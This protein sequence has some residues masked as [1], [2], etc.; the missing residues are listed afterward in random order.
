MVVDTE[1]IQ[2]AGQ[3]VTHAIACTLPGVECEDGKWVLSLY[4]ARTPQAQQHETSRD[5]AN[6]NEELNVEQ[7]IDLDEILRLRDC[8]W[9]DS[10]MNDPNFEILD[11]I[12]EHRSR[13]EDFFSGCG[14]D[15]TL[16]F[17]YSHT[18]FLVFQMQQQLS[19]GQSNLDS[20][21]NAPEQP[22]PTTNGGSG[23]SRKTALYALLVI[24]VVLLML[25][26][27]LC[28][29]MLYR[30]RCIKAEPS[31]ENDGVFEDDDD[32]DVIKL[33]RKPFTDD[34]PS[35]AFTGSSP[36]GKNRD[37]DTTVEKDI[38]SRHEEEATWRV[39]TSWMNPQSIIATTGIVRTTHGQKKSPLGLAFKSHETA[40]G[41]LCKACKMVGVDPNCVFCHGGKKHNNS[42][43]VA[44]DLASGKEN[45]VYGI[46]LE[47]IHLCTYCTS[48]FGA[49][50]PE[51]ATC[52]AGQL[53][54]GNGYNDL[55]ERWHGQVQHPVE[56]PSDL[57]DQFGPTNESRN[58]STLNA[59][60]ST[61]SGKPSKSR[62]MNKLKQLRD[63][64]EVELL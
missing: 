40:G 54:S 37:V 64:K 52:S 47:T 7:V 57:E 36:D 11:G 33:P 20:S 34:I 61:N 16:E 27:Y 49:P 44:N 21:S 8:Y 46:D 3:D 18:E 30:K 41:G 53:T 38:N 4:D 51:C 35:I 45:D 13:T 12:G 63:L 2:Q 31:N 60:P 39:T 42:A 14:R 23:G 15:P 10:L 19:C 48:G 43:L 62:M 56:E 59:T 32:D 50:N 22:Q 6:I 55:N 1:S 25:P 29:C 5:R 28:C 26:F 9:K 58:G 17:K 24:V